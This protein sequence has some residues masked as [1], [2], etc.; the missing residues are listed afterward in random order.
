M[1]S[2]SPP[3][4]LHALPILFSLIFTFI[5]HNINTFYSCETKLK[6]YSLGENLLCSVWRPPR[7]YYSVQ[8]SRNM[9][10][11]SKRLLLSSWAPLPLPRWQ[12]SRGWWEYSLLSDVNKPDYSAVKTRSPEPNVESNEVK[13]F[14]K[15][16]LEKMLLLFPLS[17]SYPMDW[18]WNWSLTVHSRRRDSW[19]KQTKPR[20]ATA[21]TARSG[22]SA[23]LVQVTHC[24]RTHVNLHSDFGHS[25]SGTPIT[26]SLHDFILRVK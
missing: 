25:C 1:H 4:L 16:I 19:R 13:I 11:A 5:F 7:V 15:C 10:T 18:T 17:A 24:I 20:V 22:Q 14:S 23:Q 6:F 3:F 12:W 26:W 21:D 9:V 8:V 2:S